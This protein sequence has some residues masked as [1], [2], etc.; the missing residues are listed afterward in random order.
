[1]KILS[2]CWVR[3]GADGASQHLATST[4]STSAVAFHLRFRL[5]SH[6]HAH[7]PPSPAQPPPRRA[8]V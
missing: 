5:H 8:I 2:K 6:L 1:M 7:L 4:H 3:A